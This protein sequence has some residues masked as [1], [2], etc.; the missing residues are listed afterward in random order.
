MHFDREETF[1]MLGHHLVFDL[2]T[3]YAGNSCWIHFYKSFPV[4]FLFALRMK[5]MEIFCSAKAAFNTS[6]K[7]SAVMHR[8]ETQESITFL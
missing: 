6:D 3:V 4:A 7:H 1:R 5:K 8:A 2:R